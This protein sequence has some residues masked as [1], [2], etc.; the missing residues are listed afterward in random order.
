MA[1]S[2]LARPIEKSDVGYDCAAKQR[3]ALNKRDER[4]GRY[5]P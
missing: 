2:K 3:Q 4:S 5:N 1:G